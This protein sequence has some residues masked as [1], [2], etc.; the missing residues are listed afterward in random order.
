MN[1]GLIAGCL[2]IVGAAGLGYWIW[3]D[4]APT[5]MKNADNP[6]RS[7]DASKLQSDEW[8]GLIRSRE[9]V[10][11]IDLARVFEA[12]GD[13]YA[14]QSLFASLETEDLLPQP[15][16]VMGVDATFSDFRRQALSFISRKCVEW[17]TRSLPLT[18]VNP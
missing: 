17:M 15:R 13:E 14:L 5:P 3:S 9:S 8:D 7:V 12:T 6:A 16:I 11:T 1:K 10:E 18:G 2:V 4:T